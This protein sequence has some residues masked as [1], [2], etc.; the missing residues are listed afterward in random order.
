LKDACAELIKTH[1]VL[2]W[3]Y[4]YGYYCIDKKKNK[5]KMET[6]E[7]QQTDLERFCDTLHKMVESPLDVYLDPNILE[8]SKFYH[9]RGQ[10]I[11]YFE[12]TRKFY[13]ALVQS[14]ESD[15]DHIQY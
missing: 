10:L 6:F 8:K 9:F 4:A 1:A 13:S 5:N 15:T 11:S 2:K 14:I 7:Y 3:T 12:A